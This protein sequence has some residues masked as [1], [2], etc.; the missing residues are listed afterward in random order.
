MVKRSVYDKDF[1]SRERAGGAMEILTKLLE[2]Y[3]QSGEI[4]KF[5]EELN[6]AVSKTGRGH[7]LQNYLKVLKETKNEHP[8]HLEKILHDDDFLILLYK[9]LE[10]WGMNQ[11]GA[12]MK[13]KKE[14]VQAI[15]EVRELF[16]NL[17][18]KIQNT[19]ERNISE[20]EQLERKVK[21]LYDHLDVMESRSKLL[22][23][24][25]LMH[26]ILPEF[27][28]PIDHG[29]TIRFLNVP[30]PWGE[31]EW[32]AFKMIHRWA[33]EFAKKHKEQLKKLVEIDEKT[34]GWNQTIPKVIDNLIIYYCK[35]HQDKCR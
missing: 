33:S 32:K 17:A 22:S 23:N 3:T 15:K 9:T 30:D 7:D 13:S 5:N 12:K 11:R 4:R 26:F 28:M 29:N 1:W 14:F 20:F 21:E 8:E 35:K 6:R 19:K 24:S 18:Y 25:K 34:G 31:I 27:F 2:R 10:S 16:I